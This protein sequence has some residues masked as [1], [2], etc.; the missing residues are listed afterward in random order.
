LQQTEVPVLLNDGILWKNQLMKSLV[1]REISPILNYLL[2][3]GFYL[4]L[5]FTISL[6]SRNIDG[7][8]AEQVLP[9]G[10]QAK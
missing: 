5:F 3:V 7:V 2:I 6:I 10:S 8:K 1:R 9:A 4:A